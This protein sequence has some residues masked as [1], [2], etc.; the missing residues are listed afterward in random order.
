MYF[1]L[2]LGFVEFFAVLGLT[3]FEEGGIVRFF[4]A[5][6]VIERTGKY[7]TV[8]LIFRGFKKSFD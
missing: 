5:S 6:A 4:A 1:R 8:G 3:V 2:L 7:I